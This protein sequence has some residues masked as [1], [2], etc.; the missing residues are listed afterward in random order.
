MNQSACEIMN[1]LFSRNSNRQVEKFA[2]L[3]SPVGKFIVHAINYQL[4]YKWHKNLVILE[5]GSSKVQ[6]VK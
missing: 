3:L 5:V 1:F 2:P 4:V 6:F